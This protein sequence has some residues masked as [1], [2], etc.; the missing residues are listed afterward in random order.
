MIPLMIR[1]SMSFA[2]SKRFEKHSLDAKTLARK[3]NVFTSNK[4]TTI[5]CTLEIDDLD[6]KRLPYCGCQSGP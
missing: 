3:A 4:D 2:V 5:R 1:S 6:Q